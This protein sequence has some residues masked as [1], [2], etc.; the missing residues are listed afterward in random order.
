MSR[1]TSL[2]PEDRRALLLDYGELFHL[3][4]FVETG[5]NE[6]KTPWALKETFQEIHSIELYEPLYRAAVEMFAGWPNVHCHLGDSTDVLPGLLGE[7]TQPAL[8]WLDGHYSGPGTGHGA[9]SSPICEELRLI[10]EDDPSDFDH[11]ILVDDARIFDGG[12]EHTLYEHYLE[13]PSLEWVEDYA[14]RCGYR[15]LLKDDIMRLTP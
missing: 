5:T 15:F 11:V 4:V 8:F 3:N 2:E 1:F 14:G 10:L 12:P 9:K 6:G 7:L 13:Y